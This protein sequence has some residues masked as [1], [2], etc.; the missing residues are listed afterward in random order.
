MQKEISRNDTISSNILSKRDQAN[1]SFYNSNEQL[2]FENQYSLGI[3]IGEV[4]DDFLKKNS[5]EV[6]KEKLNVKYLNKN[7]LSFYIQKNDKLE[8]INNLKASITTIIYNIQDTIHFLGLGYNSISSSNTIAS[9]MQLKIKVEYIYK[10]IPEKADEFIISNTYLIAKPIFNQYKYYKYNKYLKE[11]KIIKYYKD[12]INKSGINC[13]S[14]HDSYCNAMNFL[15]IYQNN[16]KNKDYDNIFKINLV[17]NKIELISS[18]FPKRI[19]YSMIFIPKYYIFIIGGKNTK[20]VLIYNI[21]KDKENYQKY[22]HLLP[23]ELME[24]SLIFINN[25]YLYMFENSTLEFHILRSDLINISPFED[26]KLSN[27]K[28][29]PMNQKFFG[30]VQNYNTILFLGGQMI[31]LN[32]EII[33]NCYE[34]DYNNNKLFLSIRDFKSFDFIEKTFIPVFSELY[35][36]IIESKKENKYEPKVLYFEASQ[37]IEQNNKKFLDNPFKKK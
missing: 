4:L 3:T 5:E 33:N 21:K 36:Q 37:N 10:E 35:L 7:Y 8:K 29:I 6:L 27:S 13:F 31:N 22:P 32:K 24:P 34:F 19:L 23:Y 26:I 16:V 17:K 11:L 1:A 9:L 28:Y 30:V 14:T 12:D 25:K 15:Y 2:I 18:K 20:E